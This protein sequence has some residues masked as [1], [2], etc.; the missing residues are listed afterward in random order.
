MTDITDVSFFQVCDVAQV[1]IIHKNI[2]P[3]L[4]NIPNMKVENLEHPLMF[5]LFRLFFSIFYLIFNQFFFTSR[6]ILIEYSCFQ[7]IFYKMTINLPKQ[8][9]NVN[10]ISV[11]FFFNHQISLNRLMNDRHFSYITNKPGKNKHTKLWRAPDWGK[12]NG[13]VRIF[14][15]WTVVA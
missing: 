9:L 8:S 13:T 5:R 14:Q 3:N 15:V 12:E 7:N 1:V 4:G 11:F 10:F 6:E 2:L